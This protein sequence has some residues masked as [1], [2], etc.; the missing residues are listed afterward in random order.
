MV[1]KEITYLGRAIT[2][3]PETVSPALLNEQKYPDGLFFGVR[4]YWNL[5]SKMHLLRRV[6]HYA[7]KAANWDGNGGFG[8][9]STVLLV[10]T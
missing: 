6:Q 3:D 4:C 2:F 8:I 5:Q 9:T 10:E 1:K 7:G